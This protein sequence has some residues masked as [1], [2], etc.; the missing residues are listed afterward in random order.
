VRKKKKK[1]SFLVLKELRRKKKTPTLKLI[2]LP[3]SSYRR[4]R[5]R[6]TTLHWE[7]QARME[8]L[9]GAEERK[10]RWE[11]SR[12]SRAHVRKVAD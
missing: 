5:D 8:L 4:W 7:R 3:L 12:Q 10:N 11:A 9:H 6:I 2:F 1:R